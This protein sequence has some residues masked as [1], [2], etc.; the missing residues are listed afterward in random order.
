VKAITYDA[1]VS[2]L[3][4]SAVS[5]CWWLFPD[6]C[7]DSV[8]AQR[9]G[10]G[11]CHYRRVVH[12]IVYIIIAD[13]LLFRDLYAYSFNMSNQEPHIRVEGLTMATAVSSFRADSPFP[14]SGARRL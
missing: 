3:I 14:F 2:G 6:V 8:R 1:V 12:A 10:R 4:K 13:S 7:R 5:G 11:R 9:L